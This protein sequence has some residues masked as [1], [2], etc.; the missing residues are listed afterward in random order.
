MWHRVVKENA[1]PKRTAL[2]R[3]CFELVPPVDARPH[4]DQNDVVVLDPCHCGDQVLK[5]DPNTPVTYLLEWSRPTN[6][7]I[8]HVIY[9]N[10]RNTAKLV[11][12]VDASTGGF[13]RK[14]K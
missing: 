13:L 6:N 5:D 3:D 1:P 2:D 8:W 4:H 14:E 9:G 12:D 10:N 11:V 7:L